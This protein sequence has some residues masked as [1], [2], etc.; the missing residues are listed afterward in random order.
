MKQP[1]RFESRCCVTKIGPKASPTG[2]VLA[3]AFAYSHH[4]R[5]AFVVQLG[6]A[7]R[8][9]EGQF[10]GLVQEVDSCTELRFRSS[11]ELLKFLGQRF[12]LA[13]ASSGKAHVTDVE[14]ASNG[15][16]SQGRR[17]SQ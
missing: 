9:A 15:K 8:P 13:M 7:T 16:N 12:D 6:P 14:R 10:E 4:M 3:F 17:R 1:Y 11:E 2:H 5:G